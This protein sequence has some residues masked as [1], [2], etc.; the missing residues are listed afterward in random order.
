[1]L[2]NTHALPAPSSDQTDFLNAYEWGN[3]AKAI[4]TFKLMPESPD[5]ALKAIKDEALH[6]AKKNGAIGEMQAKEEPIAFGLVAVLILAMFEVEG[7]EFDAIAEEMGKLQGVQS[8]EVAK[9]DLAL[10]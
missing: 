6:I 7:T 5:V 3:M 10:G 8:S 2:S 1:M 9:M 4:V